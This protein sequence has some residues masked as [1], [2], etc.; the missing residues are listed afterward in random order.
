MIYDEVKFG[1]RDEMVNMPPGLVD[2]REGLY[3]SHIARE[4][5]QGHGE[6][7]DAGSFLG[8]S[9]WA[10]SHGLRQNAGLF[11]KAGRVHAFDQFNAWDE[12]SMTKEQ[13]A[14]WIRRTF[15]ADVDERGGFL[16]AFFRNLGDHIEHVTIHEGPLEQA[17]WCGAPVDILFIDAGKTISAWQ[18]I[19][20]NFYSCLVEGRSIVVQ[21]D[22]HHAW[23]PHIVVTQEAFSPY[24]EVLESRISDTASFRYVS[25][26]SAA[27]L[28]KAVAWDF[29]ADEQICLMNQA[30]SRFASYGREAFVQLAAVELLRSLG[31]IDD[32][33]KALLALRPAPSAF[34]DEAQFDRFCRSRSDIAKALGD[35][36]P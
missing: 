33:R 5:Y 18:A 16:N 7:V 10:L 2:W 1:G 4:D 25:T 13:T 29:S 3:L 21:Q 34:S 30:V 9:A 6:I 15:A 12:P 27:L 8:A 35:S 31:R 22:W 36:S 28:R 24:F 19:L 32:A 23:L 17:R 14:S 26:V 20:A 11:A